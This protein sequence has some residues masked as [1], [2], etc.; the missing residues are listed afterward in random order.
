LSRPSL[1]AGLAL[2]ALLT[3]QKVAV[4]QAPPGLQIVQ[5]PPNP[6]QIPA[7]PTPNAPAAA[8]PTAWEP[9]GTADLIALDKVDDR[10]SHL[11][12]V[13]G[14]SA[15]FYHLTITVRGCVVRPADQPADAAVFVEIADSR[16]QQPGFKGWMLAN[17]PAASMLQHAVYDVRVSGC[18]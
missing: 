12:I 6:T 13:V 7:I 17:E 8:A 5:L 18:H 4:A 9:R 14:Q 15:T 1:F 16:S 10:M 3:T 11:S 2:A